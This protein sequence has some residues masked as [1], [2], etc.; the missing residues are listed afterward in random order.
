MIIHQT[1]IWRVSSKQPPNVVTRAL[2]TEIPIWTETGY[3]VTIVTTVT[4]E[5]VTTATPEWYL[6]QK[7][8][9][10]QFL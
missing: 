7:N 9:I 6:R 2:A 3:T 10:D 4:P 5:L 8:K 1:T